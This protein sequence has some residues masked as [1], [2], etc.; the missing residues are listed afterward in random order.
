M[1]VRT[2]R[3]RSDAAPEAEKFSAVSEVQVPKEKRR[4]WRPRHN[5]KKKA[6][7]GA[8]DKT[9]IV[10]TVD[11]AASWSVSRI[12]SGNF[13]PKALFSKDEKYLLF[14]DLLSNL[15]KIRLC[16]HGEGYQAVQCQNMAICSFIW[17]NRSQG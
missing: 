13:R 17:I 9:D 6:K 15:F 4:K 10:S 3:K 16:C 14:S 8:D 1:S 5:K 12:S 2:K 11:N 7:S